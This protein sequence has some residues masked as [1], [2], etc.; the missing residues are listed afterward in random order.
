[1]CREKSKIC[2]IKKRKV[3]YIFLFFFIKLMLIVV[4]CWYL[5][6]LDFKKRKYKD[7]L[8]VWVCDVLYEIVDFMMIKVLINESDIW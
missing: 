3:I 7:F 1:M 4:K 2:K 5:I 6:I 8:K